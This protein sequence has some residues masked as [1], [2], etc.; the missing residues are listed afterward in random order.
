MTAAPTPE[1]GTDSVAVPTSTP[2]LPPPAADTDLLL[3]WDGTALT[4]TNV[5]GS[6]ADI[7]TLSMTG[8]NRTV[9]STYW[10]RSNPALNL[11]SIPAGSCV[12]LRP[13]AYPDRPPLPP[14]C[15]DLGGWWSAD[16]VYVWG[17]ESFD[18]YLNGQR[19]A[20]CPSSA[21][22]CAVDLPGV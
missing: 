8:N 9:D 6:P 4:V 14:N 16:I 1:T 5:S 7:T 2:N 3:R 22:Q 12:G 10:A 15:D 20:T 11:A 21:G 19:V 13:L 17:G 18:V